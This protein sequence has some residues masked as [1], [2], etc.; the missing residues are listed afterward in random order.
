MKTDS[1]CTFLSAV[2]VK[3]MRFSDQVHSIHVCTCIINFYMHIVLR[4]ALMADMFNGL[5]ITEVYGMV[6]EYY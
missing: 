3:D 6:C 1:F 2:R 4:A 5:G